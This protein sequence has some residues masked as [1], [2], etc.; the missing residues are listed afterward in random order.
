MVEVDATV[1]LV[2]EAGPTTLLDAF[3]GRGQ[4]AD[5]PYRTNGRPIAQ[6]SRLDAGRSDDLGT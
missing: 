1:T 3:E 5:D 2:G 4:L 6:W